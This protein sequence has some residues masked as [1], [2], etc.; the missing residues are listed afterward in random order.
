LRDHRGLPHRQSEPKRR[1]I[2]QKDIASNGTGGVALTTIANSNMK[3]HHQN[4]LE[5]EGTVAVNQ[6]EED[7][8]QGEATRAELAS[9]G[10]RAGATGETIVNSNTRESPANL[11]E[12]HQPDLPPRI[13]REVTAIGERRVVALQD[14]SLLSH[15]SLLREVL[16]LKLLLHPKPRHPQL[17]FVLLHPC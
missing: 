10:S 5:K 17:L 13:Q 15:P 16:D 1:P 11:G 14:Q 9:S 8:L 12:R 7:H 6:V 2:S 3:S 4:P